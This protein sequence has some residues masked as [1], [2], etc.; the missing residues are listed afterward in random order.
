MQEIARGVGLA[1][2]NLSGRGAPGEQPRACPVGDH[3]MARRAAIA[4]LAGPL[5]TYL[6]AMTL[7]TGRGEHRSVRPLAAKIVDAILDGAR[8]RGRDKSLRPVL[9]SSAL[10]PSSVYVLVEEV[11]LSDNWWHGDDVGVQVTPHAPARHA[12]PAS[13]S[14][15]RA[16]RDQLL[17]ARALSVAAKWAI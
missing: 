6:L 1:R 2:P 14:S 17:A 3:G 9:D 11:A 15:G 5:L 7:A 13:A 10:I 8:D 12:P 16:R 4:A